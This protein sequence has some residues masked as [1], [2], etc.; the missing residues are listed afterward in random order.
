[1][2][3]LKIHFMNDKETIGYLIWTRNGN[4]SKILQS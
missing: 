3:E 2:K 4:N 1:M